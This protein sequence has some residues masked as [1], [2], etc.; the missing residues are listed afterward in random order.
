MS[1]FMYCLGVLPKWG[2]RDIVFL[3]KVA[4]AVLYGKYTILAIALAFIIDTE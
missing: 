4:V 3:G 2:V 1:A